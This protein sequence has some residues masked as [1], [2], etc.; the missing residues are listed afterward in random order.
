MKKIIAPILAVVFTFGLAGCGGNTAKE[1]DVT[2]WTCSA[3]TKVL[4]ALE[5][6]G[7]EC[8]FKIGAFKNES[9]SAQIII[10]PTEDVSSYTVALGDLTASDGSVLK[11]ENFTVYNEK[12]IFVET[13]K[14]VNLVTVGGYYP[15]ALLPFETAVEYGENKIAGGNNQGIYITLKVPEDQAA[16]VYTGSFSVNVDGT[17]HNVPAEIT[18][19]DFVLP[20][21]TNVKT[22]YGILPSEIAYGELDTSVEMVEKY[23]DF[24]LDYRISGQDLPHS[25]FRGEL[26]EEIID[27]WVESALK[28]AQDERCS[29][30]NLLYST[31]T[32]SAAPYVNRAGETLSYSGLAVDM[33]KVEEVYDKLMERSMK[34]G[35]N[36]FEKLGTYF[37]IFDEAEVNGKME[38]ANYCLWSVNERQAKCIEKYRNDPAYAVKPGDK[39]NEA[40]R[41]ELIE[42]LANVKHK[43]VGSYTETLETD[44]TYVPT[45]DNYDEES[46]REL[47]DRVNDESYGE[48]NGELWSYH[49]MNPLAPYPTVHMEDEILGTRVMGW[50]MQSYN[51][52]GSLY[53][54]VNLYAYREDYVNNLQLTDYYGTALRFPLA[55]GDG[56]LVYPGAPYGIYG[57][58]PSM[59]L[60]SLR[61]AFEDYDLLYALEEMYLEHGLTDAEFDAV[62]NIVN[63]RL[64]NGARVKHGTEV[65]G[66][67]DDVRSTLAELLVLAQQD[68]IVTQI[69]EQTGKTTFTVQ[70]PAGTHVKEGGTLLSGAPNGD[71]TF[72]TVDVNRDSARNE[73]RLTF[74]TADRV[75]SLGIYV[76]GRQ[77]TIGADAYGVTVKTE[78][79][80]Y[81]CR[82]VETEEFGK[83]I[84]V[85]SP[86][87]TEGSREYDY[88]T[89]SVADF[90]IDASTQKLI[91]CVYNNG[92][93]AQT[94]DIYF[95]AD[96]RGAPAVKFDS[97]TLQT[98]LNVITMD[99]SILVQSRTLANMRLAFP[100]AGAIDVTLGDIVV[101]E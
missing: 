40:F 34:E 23:Y 52:V 81:D 25:E 90:G 60:A 87:L 6:D 72:Y 41:Q 88:L 100:D 56:F 73:L 3:N 7:S 2:V 9:E 57:P 12:Y 97:Y 94:M 14:E 89:V 101:S 82:Q 19:Y 75:M 49:C 24:M 55:N 28:S 96:G 48:G 93:S 50:I 13:I 58:V 61:D 77:R 30:Y 70:T 71:K 1:N 29:H 26:T 92:D 20:T 66:S 43:F 54:D 78:N 63:S 47:Y 4:Q 46:S 79:G 16:G 68:I 39:G 8:K 85:V 35:V 17:V 86:A 10:S 53:W 62:M 67:F 5:Y 84:S 11:K 18:V 31:V 32:V 15:D 36:L 80:I 59:R 74:E 65:V 33:D 45:I 42:T 95:Q 21:A 99:I 37:V 69:S 83:G 76:G 27:R 51:I 91:L 44:A 64:F 22:S 38:M 98:G